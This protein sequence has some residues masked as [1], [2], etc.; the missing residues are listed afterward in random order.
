[1]VPEPDTRVDELRQQL[2]S[3][4]YLD[5]GV[6]RFV[7]GAAS[8]TQ[9]PVGVAI[10]AS[11]RVGLLAGALLGP[12]AAIGL[13]ARLPGLVG[14]VRDAVVL[15]LYLAVFFAIAVAIASFVVSLAASAFARRHDGFAARARRASRAAA[16]IFTIGALLYLTLWWRNANAGFGWS[17]PIWTSFALLVAVA[18][19]L[20]LGHAVRIATLA[21][22][23]A[24]TPGAG[25][26]PIAARRPS[27]HR[28]WIARADSP[29]RAGWIRSGH[30]QTV[31]GPAPDP[32]VGV[33]RP[34]RALAAAGYER[35]RASVDDDRDGREAGNPR[36]PRD[37]N[38]QGRRPEWSVQQ[39]RA[40]AGRRRRHRSPASDAPVA[41]ERTGSPDENRVGSR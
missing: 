10:R 33:R 12:A 36:R 26:P 22:L 8:A 41:R 1:M 23:A 3:L 37:R 27:A 30:L 34:V 24:R 38:A 40:T 19:S 17:A 5:A 31:E 32:V 20:L 4:G 15:A 2:K 35:S 11:V 7:L 21:V 16:W 14:G 6:D 25:L 18:I 29:H 13:G 39:P 28:R 9:S